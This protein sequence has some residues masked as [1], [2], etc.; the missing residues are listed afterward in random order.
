[1][2]QAEDQGIDKA[3]V[4]Y[5]I[6]FQAPA[7]IECMSRSRHIGIVADLLAYYQETGRAGRDGHVSD[8]LST[9]RRCMLTSR[10]HDVSYTTVG[11]RLRS[12]ADA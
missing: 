2:S 6:H 3:D 7:G 9:A 10:W 8:G 4:R 5:V 11:R 1:M 12:S